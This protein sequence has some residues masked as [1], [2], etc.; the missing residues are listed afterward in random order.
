MHRSDR[1]WHLG[2]TLLLTAVVAGCS[3]TD[4]DGAA[5]TYEWV[6]PDFMGELVSAD[7]SLWT[8]TQAA[9]ED[10]PIAS[11]SGG[12]RS[13]LVVGPA[14]LTLDDGTVVT[15][16]A[17]TRGGNLCPS[18]DLYQQPP[19]S[20][21][22]LSAS[23]ACLVVGVFEPGTT[24]ASWFATEIV[25]R[26]DDG[27]YGMSA[28]FRN[29]LAVVPAGFGSAAALSIARD[30]TVG[31]GLTTADVFENGNDGYAVTVTSD[32]EIVTIDCLGK[33]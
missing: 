33:A 29:G 12:L 20:P 14:T 27:T 22:G 15:V 18:L 23:Q 28:G 10:E 21:P 16:A 3:G 24:T 2:G 9:P 32:D 7:T 25:D 4:D 26:H 13:Q 31:C 8:Q 30:V 11:T 6:R 19:D 1:A 5:L 17:G